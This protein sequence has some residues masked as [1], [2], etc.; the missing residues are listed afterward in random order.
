MSPTTQD[1]QEGETI[2]TQA[3]RQK[4]KFVLSFKQHTK[5]SS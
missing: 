1:T 4:Y 2:V 3:Y 5:L